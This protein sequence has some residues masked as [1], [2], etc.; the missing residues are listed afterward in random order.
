MNDDILLKNK[1][2]IALTVLILISIHLIWNYYHGGVPT[3]YILHDKSLPGFSNWWGLLA[4]PV[5]T[6]GLI[7]LAQKKSPKNSTA[8]PNSRLKESEVLKGFIG[9]FIFGLINSLFWEFGYEHILQYLIL[10]PVVLSLFI[11]IHRPENV[12]GFLLGMTFTFGGVLPLGF[13]LIL[14]VMSYIVNKGLR[15]GAITLIN[16]LRN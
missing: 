8:L 13:S 16:I 2:S 10:L 5:M 12:L 4:I 11:T 7:T 9:S 6:W 15:K 1:R 14:W 3:H